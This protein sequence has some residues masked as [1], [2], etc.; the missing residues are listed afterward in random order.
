MV[1]ILA[2]SVKACRLCQIPTFVA[3]RHIPP[4]GGRRPS[5]WEPLAIH[6]KFIS[7]P[8]SLPL[9]EVDANKVSRRRGRAC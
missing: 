8:R 5:K 7:L 1:S 3:A 9:G 6:A 2:L 4:D